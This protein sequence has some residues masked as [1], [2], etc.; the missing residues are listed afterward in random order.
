MVENS[1][2]SS[3][4]Y[5]IHRMKKGEKCIDRYADLRA[6]RD[7]FEKNDLKKSLDSDFILKFLILTYT[8]SSPF[9]KDHP[10]DLKTRKTKVLEYL[11][12]ENSNQLTKDIQDAVTL[13]DLAVAKR[14]IIFLRIQ[15]NESWT[16]LV[17]RQEKYNEALEQS[18]QTAKKKDK[19]GNDTD[20]IDGLEETRRNTMVKQLRNEIREG[21]EVFMAGERSKVLEEFVSFSLVS[22]SFNIMP[23]QY[24]AIWAKSNKLP[25][26]LNETGL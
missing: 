26:D 1:E 14:W 23:E 21:M 10:T 5:D 20:E 4:K 24:V 13:K 15:A 3:C 16:Y 11:G 8:P 22:E 17:N 2:F 19:Q 25:Y 7:V 9:A 6:F 12:I 18:I